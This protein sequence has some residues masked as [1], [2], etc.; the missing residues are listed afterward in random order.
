MQTLRE[1]LHISDTLGFLIRNNTHVSPCIRAVWSAMRR[2]NRG[3]PTRMLSH[4]LPG[5]YFTFR[6]SEGLI[7]YMPKGRTQ[8][9]NAD[10]T[11]KRNG[12]QGM[13]PAKF[14]RALL[15]DRAVRMIGKDH[16]IAKFDA[17][18]KADEAKGKLTFHVASFDKAY[19][20]DMYSDDNRPDSCMWGCDVGPFYEHFGAK[21]VVAIDRDGYYVGRAVVWDG[22]SVAGGDKRITVMD[23]VYF[24]KPHV[25]ELFLDYAKRQGWHHRL[26]QSRDNKMEFVEPSGQHVKLKLRVDSDSDVDCA[27]YPYLDTFTWG[28]GDSLNNYTEQDYTYEN[29]NGEREDN[30]D[31]VVTAS[32]ERI[33]CDDAVEIG[34]QYYDINGDD[35]VTCYRTEEYIL[36]RDA[37][38]IDLTRHET[39]YIHEDYVSRA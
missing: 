18:L 38:A 24:T 4:D 30:S 2:L 12:R 31:T 13:K 33:P 7:T 19:N 15:S 10:G 34:G 5:D 27:F 39:I 17:V 35:V 16:E 28:T 29:T 32:G 9:F 37:F 20:P 22:V 21:C 8:E 25:L 23:R 26:Y 36:R 6:E 14:L 11:W 3:L 1:D